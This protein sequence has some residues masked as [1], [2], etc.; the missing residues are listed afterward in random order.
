[1]MG[2]ENLLSWEA[3]ISSGRNYPFIEKGDFGC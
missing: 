2:E 3:G 1:M